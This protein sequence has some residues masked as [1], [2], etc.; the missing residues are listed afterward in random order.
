MPFK[1]RLAAG[2]GEHRTKS[3]KIIKPGD[4]FESKSPLHKHFPRRFS[5][6]DDATVDKIEGS[7]Y[8]DDITSEFENASDVPYLRVFK[9]GRRYRVT[10]KGKPVSTDPTR[11]TTESEVS[12][13]I[14]GLITA[15]KGED[16]LDGSELEEDDDEVGSNKKSSEESDDE[17]DDG[18]VGKKKKK[19][20]SEE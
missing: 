1:L 16:E 10:V 6:V 7:L 8:G 14:L 4:V 5:L 19:K 12:D 18:I 11:L 15:A 3:G 2:H 17:D 13:V 9:K 20:S